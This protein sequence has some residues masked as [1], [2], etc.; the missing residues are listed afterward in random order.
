MCPDESQ[1]RE[2]E[3]RRARGRRGRTYCCR[4]VVAA[5]DSQHEGPAEATASRIGN[6]PRESRGTARGRPSLCTS[7]TVIGLNLGAPN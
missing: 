4:S 5:L 1:H 6:A 7:V 3:E 2:N